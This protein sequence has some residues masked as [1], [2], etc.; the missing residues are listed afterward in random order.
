[1]NVR[2]I[3]NGERL[4]DSDR[5]VDGLRKLRPHNENV[6]FAAIAGVPADLLNSNAAPDYDTVLADSRMQNVVDDRGTPDT[7][8]DALWPSCTRSDDSSAYPPRR[9]VEVAKAFGENGA[10][11]SLCADDF[12]ATTGSIIRA[13]GARLSAYGQPAP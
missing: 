13:I 5:Y 12:G 9:L 8:D 3:L 6:I 11:G 10:L 1:M 7:S 4:Y 2:C